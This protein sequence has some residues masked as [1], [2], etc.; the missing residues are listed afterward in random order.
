MFKCECSAE[1][2]SKA[3]LMAHQ[4]K[5]KMI[6]EKASEGVKNEGELSVKN[7]SSEFKV[8]SSKGEYIRTYS[9]EEHGENAGELAQEFA[10]KINGKVCLN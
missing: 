8:E 10:N 3:G 4:R 6:L 1:A 5:C 7:K 9:V 2:K